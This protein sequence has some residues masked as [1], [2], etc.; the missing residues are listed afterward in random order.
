M[1]PETD[2]EA[3]A[4]I[5][6]ALDYNITDKELDRDII[7]LHLPEANSYVATD[8]ALRALYPPGEYDRMM[9]EFKDE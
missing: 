3:T 4:P 9:A 2:H 7:N 6:P 1:N 8:E 5:P